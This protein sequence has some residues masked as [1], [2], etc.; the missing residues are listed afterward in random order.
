MDKK[1]ISIQFLKFF[2]VFRLILQESRETDAFFF[3]TGNEK[4]RK[5]EEENFIVK[6]DKSNNV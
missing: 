3:S 5:K 4:S 1:K 2:Y 6:N